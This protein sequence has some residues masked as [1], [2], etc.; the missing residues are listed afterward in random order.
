MS[1]EFSS[2]HLDPPNSEVQQPAVQPGTFPAKGN[3]EDIDEDLR[4]DLAL[5]EDRWGQSSYTCTP[6]PSMSMEKVPITISGLPVIIPVEAVYPLRAPLI[7]PPDPHLIFINPGIPLTD[8]LVNEIFDVYDEA[9]GFYLLISGHLQIIVPDDF[10][11]DHALSHK[12]RQFG[13][14]NVS[15]IVQSLTPCA[16]LMKESSEAQKQTEEDESVKVRASTPPVNPGAQ[17]TASQPANAQASSSSRND[18]IFNMS[19]GSAVHAVVKGSKSKDR[20]EARVGVMTKC[21]NRR[22]ITIPTHV[23]TSALLAAKSPAFPGESWIKEATLF[24]TSGTKELGPIA[25]TFDLDA[26]Q[27]PTGFSH[28]VSLVDVSDAPV[29]LVSGIKAPMPTTWL[30]HS[31]WESLKY[32]TTKLCLL[33]LT[34]SSSRAVSAVGQGIFRLQRPRKG[35]F[36]FSRRGKGKETNEDPGPWT[37]LVARSLLFRVHPQFRPNGV[38]SGTAVC[39]LEESDNGEKRAKLAGFTAFAQET[40]AIQCF[41]MEGDRLYSRLADGRVAFYGAF[42]V[43]EKLRDE[44]VIL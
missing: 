44:H 19:V 21:K 22:Y 23:V 25:E 7:P 32:H 16:R 9:L 27:F 6:S 13:G 30:T 28:D 17:V 37:M 26:T 35:L 42:Q 24:S 18:G 40:S 10:D 41:D 5:G 20:F 4:S 38:Q 3:H 14:L 15:Y 36:S 1:S 43:P 33:N 12:P 11:F 34:D 31:D 39:V 29:D 8:N 2:D